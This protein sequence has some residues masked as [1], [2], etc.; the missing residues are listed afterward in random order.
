MNF[1]VSIYMCV[2]IS[3]TT[4]LQMYQMK[5]IK[6]VLDLVL[7]LGTRDNMKYLKVKFQ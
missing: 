7:M 1:V 2:K 5:I 6:Y 3:C 4:K